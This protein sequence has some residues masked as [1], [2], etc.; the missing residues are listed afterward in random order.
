M[1]VN[2][3]PWPFEGTVPTTVPVSVVPRKGLK[4]VLG[5]FALNVEPGVFV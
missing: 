5:K 3:T 2:M 1:K 4:F